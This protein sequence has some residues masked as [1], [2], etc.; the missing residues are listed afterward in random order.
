M[1]I[2]FDAA[3]DRALRTATVLNTNN[4]WGLTFW[5]Y[6]TT[7][8][9]AYAGVFTTN[10]NTGSE[11]EYVGFDSTGN[12]LLLAVDGGSGGYGELAGSV[13][14]VGQWYFIAI[15]RSSTTSLQVY[16]N[17]ST[18][19]DITLTTN[20]TSRTV[21]TRMEFGAY[22]T[23]N[24]DPFNGRIFCVKFWDTNPTAAELSAE[25]H[26]IRP[27]RYTNLWAWLPLLTT[28]VN[29]YS[30]N[31]RNF[32]GTGLTEEQNA[33]VSWGGI[34]QVVRKVIAGG[35]GPVTYFQTINTTITAAQTRILRAFMRRANTIT[36]THTTTKRP[37]MR[38]TN[39][40]TGVQNSTKR[41]LM[42]RNNAV[43]GT[44]T[45]GL[46]SFIRRTNTGT[47]TQ[48]RT[49]TARVRRSNAITV[50]NT[51][52]RKPLLRRS[53]TVTAI[54]GVSKRVQKRITHAVTG[55]QTRSLKIF[56]RVATGITTNQS[57]S[58]RV[59]K[60]AFNNVVTTI[61]GV[62]SRLVQTVNVAVGVTITQT[63]SKK[64]F[65]RR[66][67]TAT[68]AQGLVE[69][70]LIQRNNVVT[71][72]QGM[73]KRVFIRRGNMVTG[74]QT[75]RI[76]ARKIITTAA[77]ATQ[78]TIKMI[79]KIVSTSVTAVQNVATIITPGGAFVISR[80]INYIRRTQ[81]YARATQIIRSFNKGSRTHTYQG[82]DE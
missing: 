39:T 6:I 61:T 56:K 27:V 13:L 37:L 43:V 7:D 29:D 63:L 28:D 4:A 32:T 10:N 22:T 17:G 9:N 72:T 57:R 8:T 53:N 55:I 18:T 69:R 81:T 2:R 21:P 40:V 74:T 31:A 42:R 67:N 80:A 59:T 33:P 50:S 79:R 71:N 15:V 38:R 1:S 44:Q 11:I 76:T 82:E 19:P 24:T 41:A 58:L 65:I 68:I 62:T 20:I 54:Q 64:L 51:N 66:A 25:M 36:G 45:R 14:T 3:A 49:L 26:T 30:G 46:R 12:R 48:T 47:G 5:L 16:L 35:G 60:T 34:V 78:N 77:S 73:L 75:S 52:I 70:V 23:S